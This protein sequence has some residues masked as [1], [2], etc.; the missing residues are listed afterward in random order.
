MTKGLNLTLTALAESRKMEEGGGG[1]G[2]GMKEPSAMTVK[3]PLSSASAHLCTRCEWQPAHR[4]CAA[5]LPPPPPHQDRPHRHG[6]PR[7]PTSREMVSKGT[8]APLMEPLLSLGLFMVILID[9]PLT[10]MMN[11]SQ[12][13]NINLIR[14]YLPSIIQKTLIIQ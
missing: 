13:V 2:W 9:P 8:V 7:S 14:N 4:C 6:S 1:A 12:G 10:S 5:P 3:P 11:I